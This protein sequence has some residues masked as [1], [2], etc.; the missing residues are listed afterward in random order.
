[1]EEETEEL[2]LGVT[3]EEETATQ[4]AGGA[5]TEEV[6]GAVREV[7]SLAAEEEGGGTGG[8]V[9][10][11]PVAGCDGGCAA[12]GNVASASGK[13]EDV[14]ATEEEGP[15]G[16]LDEEEGEVFGLPFRE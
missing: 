7:E 11:E 12:K 14:E 15:G 16:G 8:A 3:E 1:M 6:E 13:A 2:T 4:G 10:P 5:E 9:T